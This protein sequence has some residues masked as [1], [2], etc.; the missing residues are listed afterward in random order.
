MLQTFKHK[1]KY[2]Y[3]TERVNA[4]KWDTYYAISF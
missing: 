1:Y 4:S 3:T 2:N